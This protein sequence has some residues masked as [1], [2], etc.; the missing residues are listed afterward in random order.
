MR[1][2]SRSR[3][4]VPAE[5]AAHDPGAVRVFGFWV[6]LMSDAVLFA[7][8]FVTYAVFH[9]SYAGGPTARDVIGLPG[10][11]LE[12]LFLLTSSFTCGLATLAMRRGSRRE[13][14]TWLGVTFL[15]GAAFVALEASEFGRLI[16]EGHGP[17]ES[18]FLSAFFTLVATHGLHVTFGLLWIAVLAAQVAR[19]GLGRATE[20]RLMT[21]SLFWHFLDVI[22]ICVFSF[23]YL[24]GAM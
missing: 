11:L 20:T 15:L 24:L 6:Y 17:P 12:T 9:A 14:V 7:S 21:L 18:A 5:A 4:P 16:Q 2:P 1:R 22:W 19:A 8:L 13:V 3:S 23:V 10:V